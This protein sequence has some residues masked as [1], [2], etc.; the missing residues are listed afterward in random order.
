MV[1]RDDRLERPALESEQARLG[2]AHEDIGTDAGDTRRGEPDE[3]GYLGSVPA[4]GAPELG[5]VDDRPERTARTPERRHRTTGVLHRS[6]FPAVV[7][8]VEAV[9]RRHEDRRHPSMLIGR[10]MLRGLHS[11]RGSDRKGH[12]R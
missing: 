12:D 10:P 5:P 7:E 3:T 2:R 8:R 6:R 9:S 11:S 4:R 1:E